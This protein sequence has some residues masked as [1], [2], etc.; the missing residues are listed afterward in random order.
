MAKASV[1]A[2]A[3]MGRMHSRLHRPKKSTQ[4]KVP[5]KVGARCEV[6]RQMICQ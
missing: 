3:G 6:K 2:A 1:E 4:D 5:S